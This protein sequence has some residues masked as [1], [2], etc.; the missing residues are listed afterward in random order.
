MAW[1]C[2][3]KTNAELISNMASSGIFHSDRVAIV[4]ALLMLTRYDSDADS[5]LQ[6]MGSVDR[7][8]YVVNRAEAYEDSPQL[9]II[10]TPAPMNESC[11]T[12]TTEQSDMGQQSVPPI[13][14]ALQLLK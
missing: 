9:R 8:N 6:A 11:S 12:R 2:S 4:S 10:P 3:G 1:R 14:S 7:G 13:W 5:D